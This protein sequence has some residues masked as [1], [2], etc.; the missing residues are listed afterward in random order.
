MTARE[1][2]R[3][4]A[5][6]RLKLALHGAVQGVGFRPFV[7]RLACELHL[8]GWVE[9]AGDGLHMEV[10]GP[11]SRLEEF[12][13]R[14][15]VEKPAHS[16]IQSTEASWLDASGHVGFAIRNSD[17]SSMKSAFILP[18]LATCPECLHEIFDPTNR[19]HRY[20]FTNCT[21]CGPRFSIIEALPYDRA[22][23]SM[24]GFKMCPACQTEYDDPANRRFHAQPNACPDCGPQLEFRAADSAQAVG[25]SHEALLT[26]AEVIRTGGIVAVKGV[27][28]FHLIVDAR[29]D[30]SVRA[31]RAR[32]H[33]EEKPFALM[34][35]TLASVGEICRVSP[36][37]E[38]LILSSEAP[39][40]LL[41][42]LSASA[43]PLSPS[44]APGNPNLGV[45]LPSNPLHHLLMAELGFPVV[46]TSG[47]LS[48]EPICTD[49]LEALERLRGI[50]DA[51]LIHNRPI[52]RPVDD[53]IVRVMMDREM[54]QRRARGHAPL[55]VQM[56]NAGCQM[57]TVLAV[58]AHLKNSVALAAGGQV[59]I[60]QH[61]G[62]LETEQSTAA[63]H[64]AVTDLPRLYCA[65]PGVVVADLHPD[66]LSTQFALTLSPRAESGSN[67]PQVIRV[68]H[69]VAH[70]LS[71]LTENEVELPVLG[72]AWDGTGLGTDG[73]I[74]GG[75]FFH[76]TDKGVERFAHWRPFRLPGGDAAAKEPRRAALGL[77]W[78]LATQPDNLLLHMQHELG[79]AFS[80]A[81]MLALVQILARGVNAP[82]CCSVGRL[83]DAVAALIGLRFRNAFEGQAAM[84]LEFSAAGVATEEAYQMRTTECAMRNGDGGYLVLDWQPMIESILADVARGVT[85]GEIS[86]RFHNTLA[87][88]IVRVAKAVG[89][90]RVALSG[91]CFQNRRLTERA[92][93]RLRAEGFHPYWQQRVPTN[94]GGI[95]LGQIVAAR[96]ELAIPGSSSPITHH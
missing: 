68:Q 82:W 38:R 8:A 30:A 94:D 77:L 85:C 54:V 33:R 17:Q 24:R 12:H 1:I 79:A 45:M 88:M 57:P 91:G 63:F 46:A 42:R 20:P 39:I 37:E 10:E 13:R 19:R 51:F 4:D 74:W 21:H 31:L 44:V 96:R 93:T 14:L 50:A 23:T 58:G 61:I 11:R 84:D 16:F 86:A 59:F 80:K 87:E 32:K 81:E 76:V 65:T 47:N 60:S 56:P 89:C 41:P 43:A 40:V 29:N 49:E 36:L 62:D 69:H 83:F 3:A 27:G 53:S 6:V 9:N 28:G 15:P 55:P 26:A 48:D 5:T 72:V 64:R 7:H 78:E 92:V 35:P 71:C 90:P 73:T 75:E 66:Y 52:V 2:R 18:D 25:R 70:V 34:F 67:A 95:A 22:N